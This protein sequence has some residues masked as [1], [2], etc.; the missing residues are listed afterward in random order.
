LHWQVGPGRIAAVNS[1][2]TE[3]QARAELDAIPGISWQT[4]TRD[5]LPAIAE[6]YAECEAFDQN[7]ER[8]SLIGL[9][10]YWDSPR[11]RPDLDLLVGYDESGRCVATARAGCNRTVTEQRNVFL[12]GTVRPDRRGEGI[13]RRVLG[14]EMAHGLEWDRTTRQ[15]G[16]GPLVMRLYAPTGQADV[17]DLA[18]RH[19]LANE[20]YFFE[21]SQKLNEPPSVPPVDGVRIV[22]W[23]AA[24]SR[25]IHRMVDEAFHDHWG[26]TDRTEEGWDESVGSQAFRQQWSVLAVDADSGAVVGA[27]LNSAYEQD[28]EET[29]FT[30]GYT[31]E[32]AVARTHRGRGIASALLMESMRRFVAA[33]LD[34]A[35]LGV[36]SANPSGALR[37]YE[38]L[39]YQQT[40]STCVHQLVRSA[41]D[42]C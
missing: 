14:W 30:E 40:A 10:E 3:S 20:R 8:E 33:G 21:L 35:G 34:A 24:R 37:L 29:V 25:E 16:H 38:G 4:P 9:Q 12:R 7:P 15:A 42:P 39:G 13:G 17:R 11:S 18:E 22:D 5:E 31:D 32:L 28:L 1:E 2:L 27:A 19:G 26:H 36:D 23:D 41:A 6:L